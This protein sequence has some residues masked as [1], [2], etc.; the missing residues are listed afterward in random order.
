MSRHGEPK[1][2]ITD[3]LPSYKAALRDLNA[4]NLQ[5]TGRYKNNQVE[6]L[7]FV[8][9]HS[10]GDPTYWEFTFSKLKWGNLLFIGA[11]HT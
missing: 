5:E 6:N 10:D 2:I 3:K 1:E 4:N 11:I 8:W 9:Q 7:A